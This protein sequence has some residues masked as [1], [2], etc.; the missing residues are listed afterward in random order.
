M[1]Q[2]PIIF[3]YTN[4][5][6]GIAIRLETARPLFQDLS[7]FG[8]SIAGSVYDPGPKVPALF[9][10]SRANVRFW[11]NSSHLMSISRE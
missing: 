10:A 7:D 6:D 3:K 11:S 5:D 9:A 1:V 8:D 4:E 2:N